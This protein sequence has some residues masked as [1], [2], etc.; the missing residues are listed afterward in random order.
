[1]VYLGRITASSNGYNVR[2]IYSNF[3][4]KKVEEQNEDGIPY[5]A[6]TTR[7]NII[8]IYIDPASRLNDLSVELEKFLT[9]G[10]FPLCQSKTNWFSI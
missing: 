2:E 6:T 10:E 8:Q 3:I 9:T 7:S 5:Q 4:S 1:M